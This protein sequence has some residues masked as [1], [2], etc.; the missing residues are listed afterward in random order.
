MVK[1]KF[2]HEHFQS[3]EMTGI[4]VRVD[5]RTHMAKGNG[6]PPSE[7]QRQEYVSH[8]HFQ[9]TRL[10]GTLMQSIALPLSPLL[11]E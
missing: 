9:A 1:G 3:H 5:G 4:I 11:Y 10:A 7:C 2:I 6:P 8:R